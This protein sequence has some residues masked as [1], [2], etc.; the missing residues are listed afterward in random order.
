[1]TDVETLAQLAREVEKG[2]PIVW[3]SLSM[4]E[5]TAYRL[6]AANVLEQF[7][8]ISTTDKQIT[9]LATITK[10]LVENFVLNLKLMQTQDYK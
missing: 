5:M 8:D 3:G 10:L 4:D 7:Q 9:V 2:D 6:M 1:M